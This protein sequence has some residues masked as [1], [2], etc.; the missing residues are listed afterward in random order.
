[1]SSPSSRSNILQC[2]NEILRNEEAIMW[3]LINSDYAYAGLI[4][5]L[6]D[7]LSLKPLIGL[8]N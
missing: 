4:V 7:V 8:R 2:I 3:P 5:L 1:M 6:V